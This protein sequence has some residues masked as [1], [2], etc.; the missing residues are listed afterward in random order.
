MST[1][2]RTD[3][4]YDYFFIH[5]VFGHY[6][7]DVLEYFGDYL[8]TRFEHQVVGTYDKT[9]EYL[10]KKN[11]NN[12]EI[13][14]PILPALILNPTG[15]FNLAD[16]SSGGKQFWRFPNLAPG[17]AKYLFDPI[18]QDANMLINVGFTRVKGEIEL[19]MLL[20]SFYEYC[21]LRIF[22]LQMFGGIERW[23]FPKWF[24]TFIIIPEDL[25]NYEYTNE[26]TGEHYTLDWESA[27][28]TEVL[29]KSTNIN[30]LTIPC[31]IKPQMRLTGL[32]DGST[33][34]GSTDKLADWRL[35]ATIE[36]EIEI[37]SFLTLKSD[38]LAERINL[39][40]RAG[41]CYSQYTNYQPPV[42]RELS[43]ITWDLGLDETSN[44][45]INDITDTTSVLEID[46]S[47][48]FKTRYFHTITESEASS[49]TNVK[50]PLSEQITNTRLIIVNS[51]YGEL[52]YG[53]H[54]LINN[55]GMQLEIK[56]DNVTLETDMVIELY[57]YE[58]IS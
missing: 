30:E 13:D 23:I 34:Y 31:S 43:N 55:D 19:L 53:D 6:Y 37:P 51:K 47:F 33:R 20:N 18:Y 52:K 16:A 36:Y 28:A 50:I 26:Y 58:S 14:K 48:V 45:T 54:F 3:T 29:V 24:T 25:V 35:S 2:E 17:M 40:I 56:I 10:N 7:K 32:S 11:K 15:E 9:V 21:D 44:S 22:L 42:N 38:Y 46:G 1:T 4:R 39:D 12:R 27:G 57:I 5:N 41:S 49:T 8:Y